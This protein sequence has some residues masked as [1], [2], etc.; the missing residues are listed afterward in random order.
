MDPIL[1]RHDIVATVANLLETLGRPELIKLRETLEPEQKAGLDRAQI[2]ARQV[3][4]G[5]ES[6]SAADLSVNLLGGVHSG[7]LHANSEFN[8][9]ISNGNSGHINN[10]IGNLDSAI[11]SASQAFFKRSIKGSRVYEESLNAVQSTAQRIINELDESASQLSSKIGLVEEKIRNQADQND[12]LRDDLKNAI[13]KTRE[14]V[15][16]FKQRLTDLESGLKDEYNALIANF[17][18]SMGSQS[19][20]R[21]SKL[22]PILIG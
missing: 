21:K 4:E 11:A 1:A 10:A 12:A 7:I 15:D 14:D 8:A 20:T 2:F 22:E 18:R 5:L 3:K 16:N 9:F 17:R 19:V 13:S 6:L